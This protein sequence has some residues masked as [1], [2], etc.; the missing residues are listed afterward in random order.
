MLNKKKVVPTTIMLGDEFDLLI[1][2]GP[3][4]G[5]KTVTLNLNI[6]IDGNQTAKAN[7]TVKVKL[8][9]VK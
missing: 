1:I 3:N 7:A 8:T 4:T 2:T 6:F 5:G 9:I